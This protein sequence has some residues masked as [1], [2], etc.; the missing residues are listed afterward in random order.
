MRP[1]FHPRI[2]G[3]TRV[4]A[5]RV[6]ICPTFSANTLINRNRTDLPSH[7]PSTNEWESNPPYGTGRIRTC[8]TAC[9][10][11][12]RLRYGGLGLR[13]RPTTP[14]FP[15]VSKGSIN[16]RT[17]FLR[18]VA[19]TIPPRFQ[20]L[21]FEFCI[22]SFPRATVS[23]FRLTAYKPERRIILPSLATYRV[24]L[25][26]RRGFY[27]TSPILSRI[28][29]ANFRQSIRALFSFAL[30]FSIAFSIIDPSSAMTSSIATLSS[31]GDS[32]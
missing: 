23:R 1:R 29:F 20:V 17:P 7:Q 13:G 24:S 14:H 21:T 31:S 30:R 15:A 8:T 18:S 25:S 27:P 16:T 4:I 3:K 26:I 22:A 12:F 9:H 32:Q 11:S 28:P 19:S 6:S 5:P 2:A 10:W